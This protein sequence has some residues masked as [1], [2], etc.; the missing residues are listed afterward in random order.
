MDELKEQY[1]V[2]L[3]RYYNGCNYLTEHP[4]EWDKYID[5]VLELLNKLNKTL[6]KIMQ[7]QEVTENEILEGFAI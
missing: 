3:K 5:K 2:T 6:E 1:N 4:N 7:K